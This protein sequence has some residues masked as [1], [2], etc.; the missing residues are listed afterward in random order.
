M[1]MKRIQ[2]AGVVTA[3]ALISGGAGACGSDEPATPPQPSQ[4]SVE[5]PAKPDKPKPQEPT[6]RPDPEPRDG[7][8]DNRSLPE[9]CKHPAGAS[10][11]ESCIEEF[12]P[13]GVGT[14]PPVPPE[15]D[16]NN[17]GIDDSVEEPEPSQDGEPE[18]PTPQDSGPEPSQD[19]Q[20]E[21]T[22]DEEQVP[23]EEEQI[24]QCTEQ[25]GSPEACREKIDP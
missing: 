18:P 5:S 10:V 21:P 2:I 8:T 12:G 23:P 20:P 7:D 9:E 15:R 25:T 22:Q 24:E 4:T 1:K 3:V 16:R 19:E 13:D 17:N 6:R 11:R 14:V